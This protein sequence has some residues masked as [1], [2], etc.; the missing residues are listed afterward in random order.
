MP[1]ARTHEVIAKKINKEY[2]MDELL[3]RLGT[4][5]PDCWRNVES[6]VKNKYTTHFWDF[7]VKEGQANNYRLFYSKYYDDINNPFYF[8]YLIHLIV[9]QYWKTYVDPKYTFKVNGVDKC[10]LLDGRII[11]DKDYF[12]YY[13]DKKFQ[14]HLAKKYNLSLLPIE[15]K[16]VSNLRCNIEELNLSGLFGVNGTTSYINNK[17]MPDEIEEKSVLYDYDDMDK[18]IEETV[19]FVKNE[20]LNLVNEHK[21]TR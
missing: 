11:E 3:L 2:G 4:V 7:S 9:D 10:K 15:Q 5:A 19:V 18:Y 6:G 17:L 8:G 21:C 12:S 20:L 14:K 13:E 16:E 1:S